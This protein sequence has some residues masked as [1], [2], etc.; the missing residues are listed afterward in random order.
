MIHM[1][2]D[3]RNLF[4]NTYFIYVSVVTQA[5]VQHIFSQTELYSVK[6][7]FVHFR[8]H[9]LH[10][11]YCYCENNIHVRQGIDF[12]ST[13]GNCEARVLACHST[14]KGANLTRFMH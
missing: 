10:V 1:I 12:W 5:L 8:V 3:E 4:L 11:I 13:Q 6:N 2:Q 14:R 9:L 7:T